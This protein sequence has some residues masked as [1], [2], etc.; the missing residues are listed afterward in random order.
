MVAYAIE[1]EFQDDDMWACICC[2][3]L[4]LNYETPLISGCPKRGFQLHSCYACVTWQRCSLS[5]YTL[6]RLLRGMTCL[7]LIDSRNSD[8]SIIL[9]LVPLHFKALIVTKLVIQSIMSHY[10]QR[11]SMLRFTTECRRVSEACYALCTPKVMTEHLLINTTKEEDLF[12]P[13]WTLSTALIRC[14]CLTLT[15][16]AFWSR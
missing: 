1:E 4:K 15:C 2:T 13:C 10:L 9:T 5:D 11:L 7:T 3:W 16:R 12:N 14:F 6:L 8:P